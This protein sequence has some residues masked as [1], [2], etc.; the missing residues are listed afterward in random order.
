MTNR[1]FIIGAVVVAALDDLRRGWDEAA[2]RRFDPQ[3][4]LLGEGHHSAH[5]L[6]VGHHEDLLDQRADVVE[7]EP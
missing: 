2:G 4:G 3:L 1:L 5:G 7:R 6:G